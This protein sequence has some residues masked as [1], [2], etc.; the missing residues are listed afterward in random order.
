M[1]ERKDGGRDTSPNG[2]K[3]GYDVNRQMVSKMKVVDNDKGKNSPAAGNVSVRKG[4]RVPISAGIELWRSR[5]EWPETTG[6]ICD[7]RKGWQEMM[8]AGKICC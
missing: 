4:G 2:N 6:T 1:K 7:A 8:P 3:N 5:R